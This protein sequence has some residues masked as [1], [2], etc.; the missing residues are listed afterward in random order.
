MQRGIPYLMTSEI[1]DR[2]KERRNREHG[3]LLKV[4]LDISPL[5][6]SHERLLCQL[7]LLLSVWPI[8][9]VYLNLQAFSLFVPVVLS[10]VPSHLLWVCHAFFYLDNYFRNLRWPTW[11]TTWHDAME[12]RS[13]QNPCG[14]TQNSRAGFCSKSHQ[15]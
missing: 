13:N 14:D 6:A 3:P 10:P 9:L 12:T 11:V 15:W 4:W 1:K 7:A 2:I 8:E 5:E